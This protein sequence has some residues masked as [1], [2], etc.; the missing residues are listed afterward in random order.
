LAGAA[1][2]KNPPPITSDILVFPP[3]VVVS[4]MPSRRKSVCD[5]RKREKMKNEKNGKEGKGK[6]KEVKD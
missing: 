5:R 1:G 6:R 2:I 3:F 4:Q